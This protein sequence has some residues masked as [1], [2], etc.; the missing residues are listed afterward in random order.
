[1]SMEM[2]VNYLLHSQQMAFIRAWTTRSAEGRAA[3]EGL[4]QRYSERVDAYRLENQR[5]VDQTH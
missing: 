3:Y 5:L 2:D 1:M 4:A